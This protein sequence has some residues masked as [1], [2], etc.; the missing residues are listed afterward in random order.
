[1]SSA[2]GR[3]FTAQAG[4]L[5]AAAFAASLLASCGGSNGGTGDTDGLWVA[6]GTNVVEFTPSQLSG[7][8]SSSPPQVVNNSG[9]FGMPQGVTFDAMG[10]LWVMDPGANVSGNMAP[11]L[12]EFNAAQVA[13]LGSM[14]TPT[15]I[16]T[17][18]SSA[19][20]FPQQSVFDKAGNQWVTDHNNNTVL[21]FTAA[22]LALTG[23]ND[24]TPAVTISSSAF[25]GPL[26]IVFDSQGDLFIANN[27]LVTD[28]A[29]NMSSAGTSIV[30]FLAKNLPAVPTTGTVTSTLTPDVTISD[31][32]QSSIQ[33][34]W[35]LA[36]DSA[37]DLL[38]S[39]SNP[40]STIVTFMPS[41]LTATGAPTPI[42]TISPATVGGNTTLAAPN[43]ICFDNKF[44]LAVLS[45]ASPFG[46]AFYANP[47][48]N[49]AATP[50]TFIA[51]G[52]LEGAASAGSTLNAPAGCNF[53]PLVN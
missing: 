38:S 39:N 19:L 35:A 9:S 10:D 13:A 24:L 12:L 16:A 46:L 28:A 48:P 22:Q 20:N 11:A 14:S 30:E 50:S 29:G 32:G 4:T 44:D 5:V 2:K 43:G 27:G 7:G 3:G 47:L 26:G 34:P 18:T 33:A 21:V 25:N 15:P 1:M 49:G 36:F 51:P 17:I 8:T 52:A 40:P 45:S 37:G 31:D 53:G 41:S 23:I 42:R 6:N